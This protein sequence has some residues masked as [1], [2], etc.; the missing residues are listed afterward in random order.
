MPLYAVNSNVLLVSPQILVQNHIVA[1]GLQ[2]FLYSE[3]GGALITDRDTAIT[4]ISIT[5]QGTVA[6]AATAIEINDATTIGGAVI[7]I[8]A[9]GAVTGFY[10]IADA[11]TS[12]LIQN[13]G[14]LHG[15]L[16]GL[17]YD[18]G[19]DGLTRVVNDGTISAT[20]GAA[21]QR[22]VGATGELSIDNRGTISTSLGNAAVFSADSVIGVE[23]IVN[24]G[25]I[26]GDVAMGGGD[27]SYDGRAGGV[28]AGAILGG[29]GNDT[30]RPG[31]ADEAIDGGSGS[32]RLDFRS[33]P[34]VTVALDGS[35]PNTGAAA[36]DS[37]LGIEALFGSLTGSDVL[38]GSTAAERLVGFAGNDLLA[39]GAGNDRLE[40]WAGADNLRGGAGN[41][42]FV[43]RA[44]EDAGDRIADF[45]AVTGSNDDRFL[46][47]A[48]AFG[49]GS[50][51]GTLAAGRFVT[52]ADNLAQQTDDRFVFNTVSRTLWWDGDGSGSSAPVMLAD[53][54]SGAVVTHQ[55][56]ALF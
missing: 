3:T 48:R 38:I 12:S 33:G 39:G 41:D 31:L 6:A 56:I 25:L 26:L 32:D 45:Q 43:Y 16:Y 1:V 4:S 24:A 42:S 36:G 40:G 18:S 47:D 27:D 13:A 19:A 44:V 22:F 34:A 52:R 30:F 46:I 28:V 15:S 37:Y 8:A 5:V 21:I 10:G 51:T 17:L 35:R 23:R 20:T 7:S 14:L 50:A 53:L 55:D 11:G 49:L 29:D 54:Q 2:G 9:T